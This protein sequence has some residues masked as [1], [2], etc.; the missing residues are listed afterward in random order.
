MEQE[1]H[2]NPE[3]IEIESHSS[4]SESSSEN[5]ENNQNDEIVMTDRNI[6]IEQIED[7]FGIDQNERLWRRHRTNFDGI[8]NPEL[9]DPIYISERS[10]RRVKLEIAKTIK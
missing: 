1:I 3:F 6:A 7:Y 5:N 4:G 9:R 8:L 2:L 10:N